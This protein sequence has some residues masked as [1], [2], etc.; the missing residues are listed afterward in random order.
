MTTSD[1][2]EG[3]RAAIA[4]YN[5]ALDDGRTDDIVAL[6][7][8]DGVAD[9]DGVGSFQGHDALRAAYDQ[10]KPV[11][12]QR[13]VISNT[14]LTSATDHE[15]SAISDLAFMTKGDAGW[16]IHLVGRYHDTLHCDD[17]TWRFH[18][19]ELRWA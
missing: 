10:F 12:P 2:A 15:V 17:G 3:V 16:T 5:H 4:A 14:M 18:R 8:A 7:C 9:L 13:H 1:V 11:V 6:F 19:R